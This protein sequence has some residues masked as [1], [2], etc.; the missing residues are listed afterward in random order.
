MSKKTKG[1]IISL[2][3][4]LAIWGINFIS[5]KFNSNTTNDVAETIA[6]SQQTTSALTN[7]VA[8]SSAGQTD[9]TTGPPETTT[10]TTQVAKAESIDDLVALGLLTEIEQN[11][12][13]VGWRSAAGLFYGMGSKEGNRVYHVF[14]HLEPNPD[15]PIHSVFDSDKA[16]LITLI[17]EA[18]QQRDG[19]YSKVQGNG[20]RVYDVDMGRVI[21]SEGEQMIRLV[22]RDGT[23]DIITAYPK[24]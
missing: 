13:V 8:T 12:K 17:D 18:W 1:I 6:T 16:G 24:K 15:K 22:L 14:A 7:E 20:N 2:L 3:I 23:A 9:N 21:G 11:G 5:A 10:V 4:L 19:A